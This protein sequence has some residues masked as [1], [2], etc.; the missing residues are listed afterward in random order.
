MGRT[1]IDLT[2]RKLG[3]LTVLCRVGFT[4]PRLRVCWWC[5]CE[6]GGGIVLGTTTLL[7]SPNPMC[8]SCD[9]PR[10]VKARQRDL[11]GRTFGRLRVETRA[12]PKKW[13]CRCRCGEVVEVFDYN[14]LAG[15]TRA[16]GVNGC[17]WGGVPRSAFD[18]LDREQLLSAVMSCGRAVQLKVARAAGIQMPSQEES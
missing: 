10:R 11:S 14:L 16:C 13:S 1:A 9:K 7:R 4:E 12:G 6:C 2:G 15:N 17:R 8:R 3:K 18:G 5:D